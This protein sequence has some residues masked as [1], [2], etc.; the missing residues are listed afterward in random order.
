MSIFSLH[1]KK[2]FILTKQSSTGKSKLQ[3]KEYQRRVVFGS[4]P[5]S[6]SYFG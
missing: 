6:I 3:I 5:D 4:I 1:K 2:T